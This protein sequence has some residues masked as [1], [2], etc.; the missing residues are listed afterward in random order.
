[1]C[2]VVLRRKCIPF[3][4]YLFFSICLLIL[5]FL[6]FHSLLLPLSYLFFDLIYL[7]LIMIGLS[8]PLIWFYC[9]FLPSILLV[10]PLEIWVLYYLVHT[11]WLVIFPHYQLPSLSLLI[12]SIFALALSDI[13][14]ATPAFFLSVEAQK[15]LLHPL[16]LT[17][18]VTTRL[19]CI[20]WRQLMVGFWILI[21]SSICL[22]FMGEFIPFMFNVMTVTCGLPGILLSFP[23]SNLSSSALPFSQS[24][25]YF[26]FY[27][28]PFLFPPLFSPV[29][30][31]KF[32]PTL[33]LPCKASLPTSLFF[34]LLLP[35][36]RKSILFPNGLDCSSLFGSVLKY[37]RVEYFLS[38]TSL[39]FQCIDVLPPPT[40]S[41]FVTYKFTPI[42]FFSHFF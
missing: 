14:I 24:P 39:P 10:S 13:M 38:P 27:P 17:L 25:L 9:L 20:S 16:I 30:F 22:R 36:G 28:P 33:S 11:C 5:I 41:F 42:C 29:V 40:M 8:L 21:H 1:M 37:I 19:M 35:I 7:N 32:P 4:P 34:T 23:N 26:P 2:R 31:L 12:R 15:V 6:R 3:Y 18:W